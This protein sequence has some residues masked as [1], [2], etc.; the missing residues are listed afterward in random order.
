MIN[1]QKQIERGEFVRNQVTLD[2][3]YR[4]YLEYQ[5][6]YSD[7]KNARSK[8]NSRENTSKRAH[9]EL[10]PEAA[11]EIVLQGL[12]GVKQNPS[13][14][15]R[16]VNDKKGFETNDVLKMLNATQD[17]GDGMAGSSEMALVDTTV[18][19]AFFPEMYYHWR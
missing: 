7:E 15:N 11:L 19:K 4:R 3:E 14:S 5:N 17:T 9:T 12:S 13:N 1:F 8:Q 18:D 16:K 2:D 10:K 6:V